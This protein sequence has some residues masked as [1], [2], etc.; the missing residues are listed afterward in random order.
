M[1]ER[2]HKFRNDYNCIMHCRSM[3]LDKLDEMQERNVVSDSYEYITSALASLNNAKDCIVREFAYEVSGEFANETVG[4]YLTLTVSEP[5]RI[6]IY[7]KN[8]QEF[9]TELTVT[10]DGANCKVYTR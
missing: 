2:I 7:G 10:P 3:L 9:N 1:K 6:I 4:N 8:A 5:E